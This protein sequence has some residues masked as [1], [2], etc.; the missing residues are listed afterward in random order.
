MDDGRSVALSIAIRHHPSRAAFLDG[1][2]L[3]LPEAAIP[4]GRDTGRWP[5]FRRALLDHHPRATHHLVV[6]DDAIVPWGL[7]RTITTALEVVPDSTPVGLYLGAPGPDD[8]HMRGVLDG[9]ERIGASWLIFAAPMSGVGVVFPTEHI[10][11]LVA[12]ADGDDEPTSDG[13]VSR[14]YTGQGT[15]CWH[16]NPSLVDHRDEESITPGKPRGRRAERYLGEG[17]F[18]PMGGVVDARG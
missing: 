8:P 6:E 4:R 17:K 10:P 3:R 13:R 16:T 1:L 5:S 18:D 15:G 12:W 9:A 11:D 7:A 14:W 2:T